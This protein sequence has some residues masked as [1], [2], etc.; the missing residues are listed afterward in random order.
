IGTYRDPGI[1][2]S[3]VAIAT[4]PDV[5]FRQL[6]NVRVDPAGLEALH[7]DREGMLVTRG[8]LDQWGWKVGQ[9]ITIHGAT[10][11]T[12]GSPDWTFHIV[13]I[14]DTPQ[15]AGPAYFGVINY[16]YFDE[17]RVENRGTAEIFYVRIADPN[18]AVAMYSGDRPHLR[19]FPAR[20][21]YALAAGARR[22]AGQADGRCRVLYP[23][24]HRGSA[25]HAGVSDRQY[26]AAG[27]S[28]P[29]PRVRGA[30][31]SWIFGRPHSESCV[32][33]GIAA[34]SASR[35]LRAADCPIAGPAGRRAGDRQHPRV[36][37]CRRCRPDVRRL[38][39][40]SGYCD[41]GCE[42]GQDTD[43]H[44]AR[45]R[46]SVNLASQTAALI[47]TGLRHI[48]QRLGSSLVIVVGIAGVVAVLIPVLA[49]YVGFGNTIRGDGRPDRAIVL[50]H[51][52][53]TEY[54]SG[55][56]RDSV[57]VIMDAA[58]VRHD[59]HGDPLVSAEVVLAAPVARK[60]DHTDVNVTLRGV[61]GQYFAM[62][63]ELKLVAGRMFTP[64]NQELMV[65]AAARSQFEGLEIGDQVRLQDGDWKVVGVFAGAPGARG[66]RESELIADA[67]TVMSAHTLHSFH[68]MTVEPASAAA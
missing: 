51:E 53:T 24:N 4:Q 29:C 49:M 44:H 52:A 15:A 5:F 28:G 19:Q 16:A 56:S 57:A 41:T 11:K 34:V 60:R 30:R 12:D 10:P 67:R 26:P 50:S 1:R 55:L 31:G 25:V 42:A 14:F 35:A 22:A 63:P 3:V 61:S 27:T 18:Q 54:D 23:R 17:Y 20:V 46:V 32:R 66:S 2:S 21:A 38:S 45:Q 43:R 36:P 48:P 58:G 37:R 13:G 40:V 68:P 64:G 7:K 9:T 47:T 6:P 65:G 39:R 62:R 33:G 59:A 8:L